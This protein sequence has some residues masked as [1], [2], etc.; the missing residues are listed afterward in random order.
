MKLSD[1]V[2]VITGGG[3]GIGAGIAK[4]FAREGAS[5][6]LVDINEE[7]A[8]AVASEIEGD[9]GRALPLHFDVG[10]EEDV[11]RA[12][13]ETKNAFG[14]VDIAVN[15]AIQ[16]APGPLLDLSLEDWERLLRVGL[17][18]TFLMCREAGRAMAAEGRG[19]AIVNLSSNGGLAPYPG[20]GAYSTCKAGVIMLTKQASLEWASHGIRVNAICPAHVETPLTAYLKDPEIRKGRE[21]ATPLGRIGQPEDVAAGALY[22]ASDD[23]SWVTGTALVI[24]GGVTHSIFNHMPGRKWKT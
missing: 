3:S 1:R 14:R 22:L 11:R 21:D 4:C 23:A 12:V 7:E 5:V 10:R 17:T 9:G 18:G 19:G 15:C 24:D 6:V 8:Q 13:D 2:A 16:M 20:T